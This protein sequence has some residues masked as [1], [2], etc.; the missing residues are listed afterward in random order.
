[1]PTLLPSMLVVLLSPKAAAAPAPGALVI[2]EVMPNPR[3]VSPGQGEWFEV[4]NVSSGS[5]NL[6]GVEVSS[7]GAPGFTIDEDV[8]IAAGGTAILASATNNAGLPRVDFSYTASHLQLNNSGDDI[9]LSADGVELDSAVFFGAWGASTQLNPATLHTGANDA[10]SGWC[11]PT[12][13]YGS[14]NF[15]TPGAANDSCPASLGDLARAHHRLRADDRSA[16]DG[17]RRGSRSRTCRPT[18]STDSRS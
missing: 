11:R 13:T 14:G 18:A 15:G 10:N 1:M 7:S 2:S 16:R 4:T 5:V 3:Y 9:V 8:V 17:T 12:S 6:N